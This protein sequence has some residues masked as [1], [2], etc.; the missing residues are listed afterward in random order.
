MPFLN[1]TLFQ[2][3]YLPPMDRVLCPRSKRRYGASMDPVWG[4]VKMVVQYWWTD[5]S[6]WFK[7]MDTMWDS[8]CCQSD[9]FTHHVPSTL[10]Y[11][12]LW[13]TSCP[14]APLFVTLFAGLA[15]TSSIP[16]TMI[17]FSHNNVNNLIVTI[18]DKLRRFKTRQTFKHSHFTEVHSHFALICTYIVLG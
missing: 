15:L 18:C 10:H 3:C 6:E 9:P 17:I 5:S 2:H 8:F 11:G 16:P 4:S 1:S 7:W 14:K 13:R 12:E